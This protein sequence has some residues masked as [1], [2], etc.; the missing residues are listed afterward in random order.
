MDPYLGELKLIPYQQILPDGWKE[1]D[2]ALLPIAQNQALFAL[3]GTN[4]GG[5]GRTT[6]GI[7]DLRGRT[8]VCCNYVLA[9]KKAPYGVATVGGAESVT[10][11]QAQIPQHNHNINVSSK[12][13]T[14]T[15]V[16]NNIYAGVPTS[17]NASLYAPFGTT[18]FAIDASSFIAAGGSQP[19]DNMQPYLALKWIIAVLGIFPPRG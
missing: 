9:P 11:T 13:G 14:Q 7:P 10:L 2:G 17:A 1:C 19:H 16:K 5:D 12:T 18:P 15:S 8:P 6:F 3:L 4:Y